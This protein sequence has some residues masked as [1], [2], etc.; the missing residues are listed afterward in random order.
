MYEA[1]PHHVGLSVFSQHRA[2]SFKSDM[3]D[4]KSFGVRSVS[5]ENTSLSWF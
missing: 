1:M 3:Y 2:P 4:L 5:T